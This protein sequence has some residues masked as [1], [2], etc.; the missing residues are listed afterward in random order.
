MITISRLPIAY[1]RLP[2]AG[3][4]IRSLFAIPYSL[5]AAMGFAHG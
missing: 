2:P 3:A 5:F 4:L 1:Y